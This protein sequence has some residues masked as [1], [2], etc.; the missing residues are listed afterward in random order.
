MNNTSLRNTCLLATSLV[1]SELSSSGDLYPCGAPTL[2]LLKTLTTTPHLLQSTVARCTD[3]LRLATSK[4]HAF[5]YREVPLCWLR[6]YTDVS[7]LKGVYLIQKLFSIRDVEGVRRADEDIVRTLD[8]ALIMAGAPGNGRREVIEKI[9]AEL[10]GYVGTFLA[11][12]GGEMMEGVEMNGIG[13]KGKGKGEKAEANVDRGGEEGGEEGGGESS[14]RKRRKLTTPPPSVLPQEF[15]AA[16]TPSPEITHQIPIRPTPPSLGFF[17][18]HLDTANT[19]L[20]IQNLLTAWPAVTT[21]PWSSPS[22]LLSK[23]HFGTRLVPI[24]LGKSYTMENWSQKIMP[25]RDFLKT[26]ILSPEA[27]SSSYPGYLAQHSLFSQIPSLREDILTPDYCYSTPPPAPPG[28]RTHPL[29]VPIVNAWFGPAGTVS[30]LHTDP[31]ANI[32]CQVLGRKYVRLY[33]PSE[34]ERLFPRGVE[35]GGVDMSNTSR[36]DMDA[37][38]GGVEVEEWER[39]QEARYLECV[40][41]AGEGLFIPVG[42]WHYVRS[43]DTSFSVSFWWN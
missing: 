14:R 15:R 10:E 11:V 3:V 19:P 24:E 4:L 42:W 12:H 6:L 25:F 13:G 34:S 8:M 16:S 40:L 17:Q 23:T 43:L 7:I 9:L 37:E 18:N 31:Y 41:K 32:L 39:F 1:S 33:P 21:N 22:Y 28:A 5:P 35:G 36:V 30:P 2:Q 29:E 26:Y 20:Q 38:G 27:D